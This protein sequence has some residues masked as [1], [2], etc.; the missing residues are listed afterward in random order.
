MPTHGFSRATEALQ[1]FQER[2]KLAKIVCFFIWIKVQKLEYGVRLFIGFC[3]RTFW[4]NISF[5]K[6]L[7]GEIIGFL[8]RKIF[9]PLFLLK[10]SPSSPIQHFHCFAIITFISAEPSL[11][12]SGK[13]TYWDRSVEFR[14]AWKITVW[15]T[16]FFNKIT[17]S[18]VGKKIVNQIL[19]LWQLLLG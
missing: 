2:S 1:T 4:K 13:V 18:M 19:K 17:I 14:N 11:F 10:P 6:N 16:C 15:K 12:L 5:L 7:L 3:D 9:F 8:T